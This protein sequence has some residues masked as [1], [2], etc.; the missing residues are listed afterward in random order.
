[1]MQSYWIKLDFDLNLLQIKEFKKTCRQ[2]IIVFDDGIDFIILIT[3]S[4]YKI[5]CN[6]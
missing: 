1:M 3:Y 2:F 4:N 6:N 5:D